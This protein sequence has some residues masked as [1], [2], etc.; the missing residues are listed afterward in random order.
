M[1]D[2]LILTAFA[3][4]CFASGYGFAWCFA[5]LL[6]RLRRDDLMAV[7]NAT[8]PRCNHTGYANKP[9]HRMHVCG[10]HPRHTDVDPMH[11]CQCGGYWRTPLHEI[12]QIQELDALFADATE[13][14]R[15]H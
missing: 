14:D 7:A 6:T 10:L 9:G 5:R 1:R 15:R 13:P 12:Q 3:V 2:V 4:A 11:H 8:R